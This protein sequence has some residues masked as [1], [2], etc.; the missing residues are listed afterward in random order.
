MGPSTTASSHGGDAVTDAGAM[1]GYFGTDAQQELQARVVQAAAWIEM[2]PGACISGRF[3]GCDD[4]ERLGWEVIDPL[5]DR[6]NVFGFRMVPAEKV[7]ALSER[8]SQR[9]FRLDLWNVFVADR[10]AGLAASRRILAAGLSAGFTVGA[11]PR[12]GDGEPIVGIQRF[13]AENG[14]VPFP[15]VM[16]TGGF[17]RSTGVTLSDADGSLVATAFGYLP[18]NAFSPYRSHAF[19]GLAAVSERYRGRGLGALI[20]ALMVVRVFE[21]LHAG[22]IYEMIGETNLPSRRMVETCG[23][24]LD[25]SVK[26]G[27]ATRA[28]QPR[29]TR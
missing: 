24:T 29:F 6:D 14:I 28:D 1:S 9:G 23:L 17:C 2:T 10:T 7:A 20:N 26:A 18:H 25:P 8:V 27:V 12:E 5:L 22:W 16:L 11:F 21:D 19:G 13:M 3:M 15:G 4:F